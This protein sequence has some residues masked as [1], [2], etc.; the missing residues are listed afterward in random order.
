MMGL[1]FG[2]VLA[3]IAMVLFSG[4]AAWAGGLLSALL[5]PDR[6]EQAS[7]DFEYR[8]WATFFIGLALLLVVVTVGAVLYAIPPVRAIGV[9]LWFGT[10]GVA[11]FGSGGL[12]RL[13]ARRVRKSGGAQTDYHALAKAGM[14]VVAAELLPFFGW[15]LLLPYILVTSFGAGCKKLFFYR[16]RHTVDA[17]PTPEAQ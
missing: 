13:I 2:D 8:P 15:F 16:V 17:P 4:F 3:T 14:L 12:F 10:V 1:L 11:L 6:T 9:G 5:F 7:F